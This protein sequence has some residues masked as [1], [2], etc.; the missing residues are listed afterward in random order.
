M[1]E[2]T[3]H[4]PGVMIYN[5][6]YDGLRSLPNEELGIMIRA[7]MDYAQTG[8]VP[9]LDER[10]TFAWNF[11]KGY[12]DTDT[13]RYHQIVERNRA[14]SNRRWKNEKAPEPQAPPRHTPAPRSK[15]SAPS[16]QAHDGA[17][18]MKKYM[19]RPQNSKSQFDF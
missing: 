9:Q 15:Y 14:A 2:I 3:T 4:P 5:A 11:V 16:T 7:M 19:N 12:V 17:D 13:A 18:W 1:A 8:T 6:L 10:L